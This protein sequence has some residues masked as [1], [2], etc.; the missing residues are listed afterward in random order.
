ML[1][2]LNALSAEGL[3][4]HSVVDIEASASGEILRAETVVQPG[5]GG[6]PLHR[7]RFQEERFAILEGEIIGRIG[8]SRLRVRAGE[9]FVVPPDAPHTFSVEADQPARFITEFRPGLRLAEF[10]AQLFWLADHGHVDAKGRIHPLQAAV[11]AR[12][13]P[14]EFFYLPTIPAALQ[15][16]IAR[17]LAALARRRGYT[18]DP[19]GLA[20]PAASV[21]AQGNGNAAR[22]DDRRVSHPDP[23][24]PADRRA[25]EPGELWENPVTRERAVIVELPWQNSEGRAVAELTALPGARVMGEHLHAG[26]HERFSVLEGELTMVRDGRRSVLR[27]GDSAHIEPGVWHDWWNEAEA[28]AVV[29]VEIAPGERFVHMIETL[30]GLAREGHVNSK[31]MPSPLQLALTAQEFSDVIV[32][33]KPSRWVQ[34]I[35]FGALA[36]IATRRGYRATYPSL[37]RTTMAPRPTHAASG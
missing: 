22:G 14:R 23:C 2:E 29:R 24:A 9:T 17:P 6:G 13:F 35:M 18:A 19:A 7:H 15:Q 5:G 31:G 12:A 1:E 16:A 20:G 32:F 26:L 27:A 34:R 36:P 28:D 30:F 37:S 25:I 10:F 3:G 11:L 8:G 4:I 21:A 33:R